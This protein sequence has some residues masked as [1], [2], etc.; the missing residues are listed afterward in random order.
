[1]FV[2]S[3]IPTPCLAPMVAM[4][5]LTVQEND[6]KKDGRLPPDLGTTDGL[7]LRVRP[8]T[9][10]MRISPG[11]LLCLSVRLCRTVLL[12]V[13]TTLVLLLLTRLQFSRRSTLRMS[14]RWYL[15]VGSPLKLGVRWVTIRGVKTTL[16]SL[17][18]LLVGTLLL[19]V[20]LYLNES[21]LAA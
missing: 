10:L 9:G 19:K 18:A 4:K 14:T 7:Q 17:S 3:T 6:P 1:M 8:A 11:L 21:I 2:M 13:L 5:F 16:L 15:L 20:E 12:W